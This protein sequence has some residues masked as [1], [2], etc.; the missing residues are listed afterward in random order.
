MLE[1]AQYMNL[2]RILNNLLPATDTKQLNSSVRGPRCSG[3]GNLFARSE[4]RRPGM[5]RIT[6]LP[7]LKPYVQLR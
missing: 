6:W 7:M 5:A 4:A 1:E 2:R 3:N